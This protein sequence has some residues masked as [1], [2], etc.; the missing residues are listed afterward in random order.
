MAWMVWAPGP[1][2]V[3]SC[4]AA[5]NARSSEFSRSSPVCRD[6]RTGTPRRMHGRPLVLAL[7]AGPAVELTWT[8]DPGCAQASY[9]A[10]LDS[11]LAGVEAG[12]P[13]QVT[14]VVHRSPRG[15]W[16]VRSS[17]HE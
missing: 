17:R 3:T 7:A 15:R 10:S 8:G 13:L 9:Q 6:R 16:I 14:V 4:G 5:P 12:D 1:T 2:P 11:L